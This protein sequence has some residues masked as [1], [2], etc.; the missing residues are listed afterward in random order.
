MT[1]V[2]KERE[3]Q[4]YMDLSPS[5]Q[6]IIKAMLGLIQALITSRC[7]ASTPSAKKGA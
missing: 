5:E 3:S 7:E 2:E 6:A 1:T 4:N